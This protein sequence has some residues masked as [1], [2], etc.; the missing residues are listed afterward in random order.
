MND[1]NLKYLDCEAYHVETDREGKKQ[2]H[3]DG[4]CY[5]NGESYQEVQGTFCYVSVE[6]LNAC[7]DDEE[8]TELVTDAF[9][10]IKQYQG[11]ISESEAC[12]YY[13]DTKELHMIKVTQETPDGWYV[14]YVS[15][16][17]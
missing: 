5:W 11:D 15:P 6:E 8:K 4:Y 9:D 17:Q 7:K 3:I 2:I 12:E 16:K 1:E 10:N 13:K 14:N